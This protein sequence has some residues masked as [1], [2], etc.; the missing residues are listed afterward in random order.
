VSVSIHDTSDTLSHTA[1]HSYIG[2]Q[3][4]VQ[5]FDENG[6]KDDQDFSVQVSC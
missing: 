4:R 5:V 3:L 6:V 2:G 1:Q